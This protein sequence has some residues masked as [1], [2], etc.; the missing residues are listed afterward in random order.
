MNDETR[1]AECRTGGEAGEAVGRLE[2]LMD[3]LRAD[4]PWD[5]KQGFDDLAGY[6]LEEAHEALEAL[7]ERDLASLE[8]ELGD[9]LFQ[10]VFLARLGRE[11]G[12]F[13]LASVARRIEAK[14]VSRHPHVFGD[15]VVADAG[16]VKAQWED[17]KAK[18][19]AAAGAE[20]SPLASVP[21]ALPALLRAVR[22]TGRAADVGFDWER[23]ADVLAKLDEEV[24]EFKAEVARAG[25]PKERVAHEIGDVLFTVVNVARRLGVDPEQAL[26]ATNDRFARRF[27]AL[28]DRLASEGRPVRG[29]PLAE[30]DRLW[31]EAKRAVG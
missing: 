18:E 4:C 16:A 28:H 9:L 20:A 26:Q 31:D 21:R 3:R 2:S 10:I 24:G 12:A 8:G 17:L 30:L 22:L 7:R 25:A 5:R 23:D 15:A 11:A 27:G 6:L 1:G 14:L 13:D 19:R 29:T